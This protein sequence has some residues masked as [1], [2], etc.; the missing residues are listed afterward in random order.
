MIAGYKYRFYP[1]EEQKTLFTMTFGCTR[2]AW[3]HILNYRN[4]LYKNDVK[5]S[6]SDI[7]KYLT[8]LR[9]NPEFTFLK[10]I[11]S[12]ALQQKI[13]QQNNAF[14]RFFKKVAKF[15][16]FKKKLNR[17]SFTLMKNAFS[18][19]NEQVFISKCKTPLDIKW[20]RKL[21]SS[22]TSITISKEPSGKY[23]ISFVCEAQTK[24]LRVVNKTCGIDIGLKDLLCFDNGEKIQDLK[25]YLKYENKVLKAQR[26]LSRFDERRKKLGLK[27]KDSSVKRERLRIKLAKLKEKVSLI[28]K[29]FIH[30]LTSKII[31]ENQVICL[32][33]LNIKGMIKNRRLSGRIQESSWGEIIR[34]LKYKAEWHGRTLVQINRWFPSS[35][36]CSTNGCDHVAAK[37]PLSV[38]AWTC[39]VCAVKHDRDINAA[40]NIKAA[41]LA[42]LASGVSVSG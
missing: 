11:S 3:N 30:K 18:L 26:R 34:Q 5:I 7:F 37:L 17:Q 15:P 2:F 23:Y 29:D 28:R 33:D 39:P 6:N 21:P 24:P 42:V 27:V 41:G 16:R 22:P 36:K 20:S 25:A 4:E 14:D 1:N 35:K 13:I 40:R 8:S 9:N 19:K 10:S 32:E 38:R 31:N 12:V